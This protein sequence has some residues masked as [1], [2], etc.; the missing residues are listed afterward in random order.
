MCTP[1]ETKPKNQTPTTCPVN[2]SLP[3]LS[4]CHLWLLPSSH[5]QARWHIP[6]PVL[7]TKCD[8][9][10]HLKIFCMWKAS[11]KG[12]NGRCAFGIFLGCWRK[13]FLKIIYSAF[14]LA[15]NHRIC[16]FNDLC[17][18]YVH[19]RPCKTGGAKITEY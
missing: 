9:E 17:H 11:R 16:T 7:Q 5:I 14:E 19:N 2:A 8:N 12:S 15:I 18:R 10:P 13:D 1:N 6:K 3:P 4:A